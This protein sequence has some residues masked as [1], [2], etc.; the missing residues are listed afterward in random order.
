MKLLNDFFSII[1]HTN[2]DSVHTFEIKLNAHHRIYQGHF[3]GQ[4]VTPGVIQLQIVDELLKQ[5]INSKMVIKQITQC[6][7]LHILNPFNHNIMDLTIN[8]EIEKEQ[9]I[10]KAIGFWNDIVFFKL[11]EIYI[12]N[13]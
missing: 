2:T 3:P 8:F 11:S 10:V 13:N 9:I 6:K 4:P 12:I 7:Y 5:F 1:N